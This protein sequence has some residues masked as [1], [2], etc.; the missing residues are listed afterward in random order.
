M[1]MC[2]DIAK[3]WGLRDDRYSVM[4]VQQ[5]HIPTET[6]KFLGERQTSYKKKN[7]SSVILFNN[8]KC[9]ALTPDCV[10]RGSGLELHQ[11]KWLEGDHLV[12]A[13]PARWNHLVGVSKPNPD[14]G[15][16]HFTLG[17]PY[18]QGFERVEFAAEWYR[19]RDAA[20]YI[21]QGK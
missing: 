17:G 11:F 21:A 1:I 9:T 16:V 10:N 15:L 7:W 3:L 13:L 8:P 2:D 19:E 12:G 4:C 14:A 20:N 18:F 6:E 5:D